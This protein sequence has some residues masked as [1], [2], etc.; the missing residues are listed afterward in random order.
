MILYKK[1]NCMQS[2]VFLIYKNKYLYNIRFLTKTL[3]VGIFNIL[4]IIF[5]GSV[6]QITNKHFTHFLV[7]TNGFHYGVCVTKSCDLR[8][9]SMHT[10]SCQE[11]G[12]SRMVITW[13]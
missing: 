1:S 5:S 6:S 12:L 3:N 13:V 11:F 7:Y 9:N 8:L 4:C 10:Y 2:I